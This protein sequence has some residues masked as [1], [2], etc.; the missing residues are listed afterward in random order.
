MNWS[1]RF[2]HSKRNPTAAFFTWLLGI[3]LFCGPLSDAQQTLEQRYQQAVDSFNNGKV[4]DACDLFQQIEKESPGYKQIHT[5]LN[6]ACVLSRRLYVMEEEL[7]NEGTQLFKQGDY[8]DAKQK[9]EQSVG[10]PIRNPKYRAQVL[11][12]LKDVE[13]RQNEVSQ[14]QEAVKLFNE[15]KDSEAAKG[16]TGLVESSG[17]VSGEARSYLRRIEE[18]RE[19]AAFSEGVHF[20][21][22]GDF[23]SARRRFQDVIHLNGKKRADAEQYITQTDAAELDRNFDAGIAAFQQ[24]RFDDARKAFDQVIG[25]G[26]KRDAEAQEYLKRIDAA[27]KQEAAVRTA[28]SI[29]QASSEDPKRRAG[30]LVIEAQGALGRKEYSTAIAKLGGAAALDPARRDVSGLTDKILAQALR[31]GVESYLLAK[32][33]DAIRYLTEYLNNSGPRSSLAYFVR[34]AAHSSRYYLSGEQDRAEKESSLA[35]FSTLRKIDRYY[36]PPEEIVPPKIM[37]L[38]S[39]ASGRDR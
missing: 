1:I 36:Q 24:K 14:F 15:G 26:S 16:F 32:Y 2:C 34:G 35:D 37:A 22:S 30:Q 18:R 21:E 12:Y 11:S 3:F 20:F 19:E 13:R 6:P 31:A 38:Y 9:F 17:V 7:F 10:L 4:E 8:D 29:A 27:V 25:K 23:A 5:Y 28:V 39:Q 33:E